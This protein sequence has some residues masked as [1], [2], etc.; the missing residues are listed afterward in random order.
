MWY[1]YIYFI[2][3]QGINYTLTYSILV[4]LRSYGNAHF[5]GYYI[6]LMIPA[7]RVQDYWKYRQN[8]IVKITKQKKVKK[9]K[10]VG[11]DK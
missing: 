7:V 4:V 5:L 3:N 8:F 6:S 1:A 11:I 2:L 9:E 10:M